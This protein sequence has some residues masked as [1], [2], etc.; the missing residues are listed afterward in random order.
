ML[1]DKILKMAET[2]A[3]PDM[4]NPD[5]VVFD[6]WEVPKITWING[7]PG[8]GKSTWIVRS[9]RPNGDLI[10]TTTTEAAKD[11]KEK[12]SLRIGADVRSKVRTLK[13]VVV[14]GLKAPER[15][16]CHRLMVDEALMNHFGEIVMAAMVTSAKEVLLIGDVNQLPYI[17]RENLFKQLYVRPELVASVSQDL[18]CT[19]RNPMDVAYALSE[20]YS[21]IYSS[22]PVVK[23]LI[24]KP[25]KDEQIPKSLSNTLYLVHTQGE[26]QSL[27]IEGYG[28]GE[29][30]RVL[31]I[32]EAQGLTYGRVVIVRTTTKS[33]SYTTAF[34]MQWWR[35]RD[36]PTSVHTIRTT[37]MTR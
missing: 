30:S 27:T 32:H 6:S 7:V 5:S 22:R 26:K 23:S 25:F 4:D 20:V 18:L 8:C 10:V 3:G 28:K 9:F 19:Y 1:D 13:S 36:T 14:N 35:S 2:I 29:G 37:V 12:L 34:H 11:L 17:D 21:G 31:T 33:S 24:R 16:S 15:G